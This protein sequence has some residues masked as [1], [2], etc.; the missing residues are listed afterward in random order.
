MAL[1]A[2]HHVLEA[3]GDEGVL[4]DVGR[5]EIRVLDPAQEAFEDL[6]S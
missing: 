1:A 5:L 3:L 4:R 2:F 6:R